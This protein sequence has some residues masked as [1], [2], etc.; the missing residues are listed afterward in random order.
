M[1]PLTYDLAETP[2]REVNAALHAADLSGEFL[3]KN[4][5]GAHNVAVGVNA[6]VK[7]TVDGHLG[8]YGAGMLERNA[9]VFAV[10]PG[11][12]IRS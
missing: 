9:G 2:L 3:I 7:I 5:A 6:P 11:L 10:R 12:T 4:P 1:E 8:Y